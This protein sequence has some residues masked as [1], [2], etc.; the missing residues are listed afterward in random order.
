MT[1]SITPLRIFSLF[2][3]SRRA[4]NITEVKV[5]IITEEDEGYHRQGHLG[6]GGDNLQSHKPD[7]QGDQHPPL[8]YIVTSEQL[9][10]NSHYFKRKL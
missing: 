2:T 1:L 3:V 7:A 5:E 9:A 4:T 10:N 8:L 6:D